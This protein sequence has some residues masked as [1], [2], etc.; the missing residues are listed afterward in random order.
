MIEVEIDG[1]IIRVGHGKVNKSIEYLLS[2]LA[3]QSS[4]RYIF[5]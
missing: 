4:I 3:K 5:G 1:V 2:Q